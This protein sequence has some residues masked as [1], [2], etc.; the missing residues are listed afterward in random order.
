MVTKL[1]NEITKFEQKPHESLIEAWE[2]Y[3]LSIDRCP[4]HN[5]VLVTQI[6]TFYNGLTLSHRDTINAAAGGTFMQ[7][8]P[9]ECYELIENMTAHHNYWDTSAIRDET[10]RNISSTSTTE[11]PEP[12]M[13]TLKRLL[14]LL[15]LSSNTVP[16]PQEDLKAITTRSG[17]TLA[18][19]SVS[20][21][22]LSTEIDQE[23]KTITDQV[24]TRSTNNVL[25]LVVQLSPASTSF[26]T[27][28][29]S[30]MPEVT[31]DTV[32][33]STKKF[34]PLVA[35]TQILIYE[36]IVALKPK[37]TIPYPSRVNKQKLRKKDDNLALKFVEIFRNLHFELSFANALL[38]MPK[39][40]LM[41]KSLLNNKE[42]LFDLATTPVSENCSVVI[43]KKL[44]EKL[45]DPDKSL[46]PYD[47]LEFDECLD[48]AD[49]GASINLM[50]LFIWKKLSFP[51]L[52]STQMILELADRS[53][54]QPAG[55][56]KVVFLKL[57]KFHFPTDFVSVN[58]VHDA[59]VPLILR[60]PFLQIER[61]LI[62]CTLI[63]VYGEE[64]TH[65][66]DDEAI[67]FKVGQTSTYSYNDVESINRI[68]VIDVACEEHVQEVLGFFDNSKSGN[69]TPIS[70]PIFAL[71]SHSLTPF[72]GG[73]F[74]LEEIKACLTSESIQ[75]GIDDANLDLEGY[76]RL[77]EELLNNDP[78]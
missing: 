70:D 40:A 36:L 44:P 54:N 58:Y 20:P 69:P 68:G 67:T 30:K 66:V 8:T 26:S 2:R 27:I 64:L 14:M 11:N 47:F 51:E 29:S 72:E 75:T 33:P 37:P 4:N 18:E 77:L 48:L 63:D 5:M 15:Q 22:I 13:A 52:T 60:R 46:I 31:K 53:T 50:P 55:I 61:T 41:L 21:H 25:P 49:L 9:K 45:G 12:S 28:S 39:F 7:K 23:P 59:C 24:L 34:Q 1:R 16:N 32:Q 6:N 74:I 76:I 73:D 78:S 65:R 35:Q 42:K 10:S 38:H 19:P 71:S 57:G 17:V 3:K 56:A 62:D 43:L